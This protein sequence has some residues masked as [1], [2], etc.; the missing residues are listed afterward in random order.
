[1]ADFSIIACQNKPHTYDA[2]Q[3]PV[4]LRVCEIRLFTLLR[5]KKH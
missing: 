2:T 3:L 5:T 4:S 1:M